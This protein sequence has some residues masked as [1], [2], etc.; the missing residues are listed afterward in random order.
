MPEMGSEDGADGTEDGA[1]L[2]S[3]DAACDA[4]PFACAACWENEPAASCAD[5]GETVESGD[6]FAASWASCV[7]WVT[8]SLMSCVVGAWGAVDANAREAVPP[9]RA[10]AAAAVKAPRPA[11]RVAWDDEWGAW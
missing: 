1:P 11:R 8:C 3:A 6:D 4:W 5:A 2:F 7:P 10:R 9:A